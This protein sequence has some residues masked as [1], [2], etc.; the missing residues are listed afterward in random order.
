MHNS[1]NKPHFRCYL[2]NPYSPKFGFIEADGKVVHQVKDIL[3]FYAVFGYTK[4]MAKAGVLPE[5][6]MWSEYIYPQYSPCIQANII[7]YLNKHSTT[8]IEEYGEQSKQ[9]LADH[10]T[11]REGRGVSCAACRTTHQCEK[12]IADSP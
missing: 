9:W 5:E 10:S 12:S 2:S 7:K 11:T 1:A 3:K 6:F 4:A 8:F